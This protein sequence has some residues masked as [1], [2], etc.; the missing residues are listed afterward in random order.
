MYNLDRPRTRPI[1]NWGLIAANI[2]FFLFELLYTHNL[3][4]V[5]TENLF[6]KLGLVPYYISSALNGVEVFRIGTL[7]TAM[8]LHAGVLHIAGNMLYL[9]VFGGKVEDALGHA[10]FLAFYVVSGIV[11]G[12]FQVYLA[13][14]SGPPEIYIPG[15]G[16]SGA[17]SGV[18]AASLIFFP[19]SRVVSVVGYFIVPVRALWFIGFWFVLQLLYSYFG[20]NSGVAY[21]AHL[22]GFAAGLMMGALARLIV[23]PTADEEL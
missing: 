16:A 11:A 13:A 12:L 10:R 19:R 18:L 17:I 5:P 23:G 22:G 8:F 14:M 21:G 3:D 2:L 6:L 9:F 4:A 7:I 15:I 20:V 1:V